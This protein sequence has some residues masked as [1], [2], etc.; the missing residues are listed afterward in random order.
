MAFALD[1]Q[2]QLCGGGQFHRN[3][4]Y[5]FFL[6]VRRPANDIAMAPRRFI[7]NRFQPVFSQ[8]ITGQVSAGMEI[9]F[10]NRRNTPANSPSG[11][12]A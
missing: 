10:A 3:E 5:V 2:P 1:R 8:L 11:F 12:L 6:V 4:L 9:L 7:T